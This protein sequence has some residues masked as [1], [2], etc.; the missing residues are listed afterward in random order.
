LGIVEGKR[1]FMGAF[2]GGL[3]FSGRPVADC[4]NAMVAEQINKMKARAPFR[5]LVA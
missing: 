1:L 5:R 4:A 3:A 2:T